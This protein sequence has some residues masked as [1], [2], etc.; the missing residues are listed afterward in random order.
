VFDAYQVLVIDGDTIGSDFHIYQSSGE[1][2]EYDPDNRAFYPQWINPRSLQPTEGE[3]GGGHRAVV[4]QRYP[5]DTGAGL[6]EGLFEWELKCYKGTTLDFT[7]RS[8]FGFGDHATGILTLTNGDASTMGVTAVTGGDADGAAGNGTLTVNIN[9]DPDERTEYDSGSDTLTV[10]L[11]ISGGRNTVGDFVEVAEDGGDFLFDSI[12]QVSDT[13]TDSTSGSATMTGG[14]DTP[15]IA[16]VSALPFVHS[17]S[18][19]YLYVWGFPQRKKEYP[20]HYFSSWMISHDGEIW[21]P[22]GR[23]PRDNRSGWG[24]VGQA[25]GD[26]VHDCVKNTDIID[27]S[28]GREEI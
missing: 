17:S 8:R 28:P 18:D 5:P 19:R 12:D 11:D 23:G 9:D 13:I 4:F 6:G 15:G 24:G 2:L 22:L 16:G 10:Y 1:P 14:D 26:I 20:H 21:N 27:L 7:I 3:Q 25:P